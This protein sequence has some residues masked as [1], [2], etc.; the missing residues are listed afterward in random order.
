MVKKHGITRDVIMRVSDVD[1]ATSIRG[2]KLRI[3]SVKD[4][5]VD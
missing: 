2:P 1:Q 3:T 5:R 4:Y